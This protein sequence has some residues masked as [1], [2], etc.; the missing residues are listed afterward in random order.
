M[1]WTLPNGFVVPRQNITNAMG[2]TLSGVRTPLTGVYEVC[3]TDVALAGWTYD[4]SQNVETCET[5]SV[6]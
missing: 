5:I 1:E 6:P 3:V 4:P 2:F